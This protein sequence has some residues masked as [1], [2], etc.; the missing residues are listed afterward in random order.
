MYICICIKYICIHLSF[1]FFYPEKSL[2]E[3]NGSDHVTLPHHPHYPEG[4]QGQQ[5][6]DEERWSGVKGQPQERP[7][8]DLMRR[9]WGLPQCQYWRTAE[10]PRF[11]RSTS[12]LG[13]TPQLASSSEHFHLGTFW[14]CSSLSTCLWWG[15]T[16]NY[17]SDTA[18]AVLVI[19]GLR[20]FQGLT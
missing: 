15:T 3:S 1:I 8:L 7:L 13:V 4:P 2:S 19:L 9:S 17:Q 16:Q 14:P 11:V 18:A 20:M 6:L 5:A 12:R 10:R